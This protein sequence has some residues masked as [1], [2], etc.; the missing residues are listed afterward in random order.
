MTGP[1]FCTS[2]H[3]HKK[4]KITRFS[5][6]KWSFHM[7]ALAENGIGA[8]FCSCRRF[9]MDAF[10]RTTQV[11][12]ETSWIEDFNDI[13][14]WGDSTSFNFAKLWNFWTPCRSKWSKLTEITQPCVHT[15]DGLF[16][17]QLYLL[18]E[19]LEEMDSNEDTPLTLPF[20]SFVSLSQ[21]IIVIWIKTSVGTTT[22]FHTGISSAVAAA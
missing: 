16:I 9:P 20:A 19:L 13:G 8:K 2:H 6:S 10:C 4:S 7:N 12:L 15:C 14:V 5:I 1:L 3:Y 21:L 17:C 18:P 22:V 11:Y